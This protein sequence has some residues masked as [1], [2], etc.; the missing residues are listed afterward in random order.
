MD[1]S[2]P[3][4]FAV[5]QIELPEDR[6]V[7]FPR[8]RTRSQ[9]KDELDLSFVPVQ[10]FEELGPFYFG[11]EGF[12]FKVHGFIGATRMFI[13]SDDIVEPFPVEAG[14]ETTP[15]KTCCTRNNDHRGANLGFPKKKQE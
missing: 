1:A 11:L 6:L 9:M 5:I 10:P 2:F 13:H 14:Y 3:D 7:R 8:V 12:P 15:D 4:P